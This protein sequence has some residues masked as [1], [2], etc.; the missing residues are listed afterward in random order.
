MEL[1]TPEYMDTGCEGSTTGVRGGGA[2]VLRA[3]NHCWTLDRGEVCGGP[4]IHEPVE[5][6]EDEERW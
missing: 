6:D 3:S 1:V 2:G 4:G 5:V